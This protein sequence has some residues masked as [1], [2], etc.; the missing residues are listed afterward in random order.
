M[1]NPFDQAV[2]SSLRRFAT[3]RQQGRRFHAA[4]VGDADPERCFADF[5]LRVARDDRA[6]L[7]KVYGSVR[8]KAALAEGGGA[9]GGYLV[10]VELRY[11]LL[12]DVAEEALIRPRAFVQPMASATLQL[13]LPNA[14]TVQAAGTPPFFGG[15]LLRWNTEGVTASESE[16]T[17][18]QV[19]LTAHLLKGYALASQPMLQDGG[20]PLESYLRRLFSRAVAWFEDYA[21]LVG[22]GV[23]KPLGLLTGGGV[24]AVTRN[25]ATDFK[26]VD[27]GK[28]LA[29]L[30][31][32]SFNRAVWVVHTTVVEK[33]VQVVGFCPNELN[34]DGTPRAPCGFLGTRPVFVS[35]KVPAL[36]TRGD[37]SLI[38]PSLYVVGDRQQVSIDVNGHTNFFKNQA[39]WRIAERVDG[40]PWFE[41]PITLQDAATQV[42]PFVVLN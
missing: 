41:A 10:P 1:N 37:V 33:L 16:P 6:G 26:L 35:E 28:M 3:E 34:Y 20:L 30:L 11:E 17:F 18:G 24:L 27:V 15:I 40:R 2:Q 39:T 13:P 25:A 32:A 31:P 29:R 8:A 5:L 36:G 12:A 23:G 42:S 7:E 22:D 19:E 14:T 38:D 4:T 21:F 9:T